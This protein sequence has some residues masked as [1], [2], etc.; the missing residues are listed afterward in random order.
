[1]SPEFEAPARRQE[2]TAPLLPRAALLDVELSTL[3][4][5]TPMIE[6][7]RRLGVAIVG[8]F[9][10]FESTPG[11]PEL[12]DRIQQ[13]ADAGI[14]VVKFAVV[15]ESHEA[16]F[17][18]AGLV[19]KTVNRGQLISAMGMGRLGKLSRL[20]LAS[21]GSCLNYGFLQTANAPGQWPAGELRRLIGEI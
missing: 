2:L 6:E 1:A 15:I 16:L 19:E 3:A 20:V 8:S 9:H 13:A 10:D 21:A 12:E 4:E 18:L 11:I 7:A 14:D 5:M 17:D